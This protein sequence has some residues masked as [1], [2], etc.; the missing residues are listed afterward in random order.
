[1]HH[2]IRSTFL[3]LACLAIG[4]VGAHAAESAA[5][6][7]VSVTGAGSVTAAPDTASISIGVVTEA[8]T[9]RDALDGNSA[10]MSRVIVELKGQKVDPKDIQTTGFSVQPKHQHFKDGKPPVI[11]G[12]RVVNS[13]RIIVRNLENLGAILDQTV[14]QGSNQING[15]Q[16]SIENGEDL[17]NEAR[18][19]AM[20]DARRKAELYAAA[21]KAKLGK[22][23]T[24]SEDAIVRPPQPMLRPMALEA[25]GARVPVEAG[26]QQITARIRVSWELKN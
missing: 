10:A 7:L 6:R 22:V 13:A 11:V 3:V 16:F 14:S 26:S 1:M 17:E 19:K 2:P 24:I 12:Y 5:K 15:I 4:T 8:E 20:K 21:E 25:R 18:K 23:I 9:A